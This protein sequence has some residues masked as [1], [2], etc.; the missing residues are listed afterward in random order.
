MFIECTIQFRTPA[1]CAGQLVDVKR[2]CYRQDLAIA[3][4]VSAV[5]V[6]GMSFAPVQGRLEGDSGKAHCGLRV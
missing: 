6:S 4:S 3:E 2:M 5:E 1:A